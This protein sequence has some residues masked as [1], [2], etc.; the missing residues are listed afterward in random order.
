M[1]I[2]VS[3]LWTSF[4]QLAVTMEKVLLVVDGHKC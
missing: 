4:M 3:Y 2:I 1:H